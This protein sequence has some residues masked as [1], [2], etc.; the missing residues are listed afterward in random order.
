MLPRIDSEDRLHPPASWLRRFQRAMD[1]RGT[2]NYTMQ[3][4]H[5]ALPEPREWSVRPLRDEA[6]WMRL[7]ADR[8][9]EPF[10]RGQREAMQQAAAALDR[11]VSVAED[12][13]QTLIEVRAT[14]GELDER[15]RHARNSD[16]DHPS[17]W[18]IGP[19]EN[20][21]RTFDLAREMGTERAVA[22]VTVP[23]AET[24]K[25]VVELPLA[26]EVAAAVQDH[27]DAV[28]RAMG[29]Q[30]DLQHLVDA[31]VDFIRDQEAEILTMHG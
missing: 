30:A 15:F 29:Q 5:D 19:L 17:M 26:P 22:A 23:I 31:Y 6:R 27:V 11:I 2:L 28:E 21:Y 1:V 3:R 8:R 25:A 7:N 18:D 4:A 14:R 13:T 12:L 20:L 16:R 9:S 24:R 10:G